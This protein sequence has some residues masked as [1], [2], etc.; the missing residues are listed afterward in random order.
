MATICVKPLLVAVLW[1]IVALLWHLTHQFNL[2]PLFG[3]FRKF[4]CTTCLSPDLAFT[5]LLLDFTEKCSL[6]NCKGFDCKNRPGQTSPPPPWSSIMVKSIGNTF[7][8]QMALIGQPIQSCARV[9][10]WPITIH[11]W[12]YKFPSVEFLIYVLTFYTLKSV[13]RKALVY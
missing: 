2:R 12:V 10:D 11:N 13:R 1:C 5:P 4:H 3:N 9:S 6:K 8:R 7:N